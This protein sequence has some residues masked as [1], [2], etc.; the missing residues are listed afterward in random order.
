MFLNAN[1][2]METY[3]QNFPN[4]KSFNGVLDTE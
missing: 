1:I 3:Q 2:K 4:N